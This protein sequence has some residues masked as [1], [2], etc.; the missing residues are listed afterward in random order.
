MVEIGKL[1]T[2]IR[3]KEG[4]EIE[5]TPEDFVRFWRQVGEFTTLSPSSMGCVPVAEISIAH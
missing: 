3:N 4:E 5:I 2:K 1:V